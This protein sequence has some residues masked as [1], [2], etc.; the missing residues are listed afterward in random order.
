MCIMM[1]KYHEPG[2]DY[3]IWDPR[4]NKMELDSKKV[5][6]IYKSNLGTGANAIIYGPI[7]EENKL[8]FRIYNPDG[9]QRK[10]DK[11]KIRIILE[12]LRNANYIDEIKVYEGKL[13]ESTEGGSL[14]PQKINNIGFVILAN[15]F[16]EELQMM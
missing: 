3:F 15:Q 6:A 10:L 8:N 12:Y 16:V 2:K 7:K 11:D 4:K 5:K 13:Q 1:E 9:S 14:I